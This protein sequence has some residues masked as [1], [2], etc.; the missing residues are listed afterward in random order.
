MCGDVCLISIWPSLLPPAW[1]WQVH[2]PAKVF[3][4]I[5]P[6]ESRF[7]CGVVMRMHW[8]KIPSPQQLPW[9]DSERVISATTQGLFA[10]S[11]LV[12]HLTSDWS[13]V[14]G[15][16]FSSS[17]TAEGGWMILRNVITTFPKPNERLYHSETSVEFDPVWTSFALFILLSNE[18]R[19]YNLSSDGYTSV[20][21]LFKLSNSFGFILVCNTHDPINSL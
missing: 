17:W 13:F 11:L 18:K 7:N 12:L 6:P 19:L 21:F 8:L 4:N 14:R 10:K 2:P 1:N 20:F 15:G 3:F 9:C 16:Y 5:W